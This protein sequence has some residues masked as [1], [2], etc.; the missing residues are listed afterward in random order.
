MALANCVQLF[1]SGDIVVEDGSMIK[2]T[3][4]RGKLTKVKEDGLQWRE[5]FKSAKAEIELTLYKDVNVG[6][7]VLRKQKVINIDYYDNAYKKNYNCITVETEEG[8]IQSMRKKDIISILPKSKEECGLCLKYKTEVGD[9]PVHGEKFKCDCPPQYLRLHYADCPE[10]S[11]A[12]RTYPR[13]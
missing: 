9:C 13:N 2:P 11:K 5:P 1:S 4:V 8:C 10:H 12:E 7:E 6:D 3:K